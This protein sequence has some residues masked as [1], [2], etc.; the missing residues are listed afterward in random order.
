MFE[1][2]A[3]RIRE[4]RGAF[5]GNAFSRLERVVATRMAL[6]PEGKVSFS[7]SPPSPFPS[8]SPSLPLFLSPPISPALSNDWTHERDSSRLRAQHPPTPPQPTPYNP[9]QILIG[10]IQIIEHNQK[11]PYLILRRQ[12]ALNNRVRIILIAHLSL[13]KLHKIP[14]QDS[15]QAG[16][17]GADRTSLPRG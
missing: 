2:D 13:H 3:Q 5:L 14:R 16:H 15:A 8:P 10:Y 7:F 17:Y 11:R 12:P 9:L 4:E 6:W 1:E